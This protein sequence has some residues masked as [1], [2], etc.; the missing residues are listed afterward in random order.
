MGA[1][2]VAVVGGGG[3]LFGDDDGLVVF[4][5]SWSFGVCVCVFVYAR[6]LNAKTP[7]PSISVLQNKNQPLQ[8]GSII[9]LHFQPNFYNNL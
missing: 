4:L 5:D 7:W 6:Y 9:F 8:H 3:T 2:A 1:A